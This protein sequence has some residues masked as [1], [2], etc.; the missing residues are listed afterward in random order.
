M[1]GAGELGHATVDVWRSADNFLKLL[2][3]LG[4]LLFLSLY[5]IAKANRLENFWQFSCLSL[6][7]HFRHVRLQMCTSLSRGF[8]A[9]IGMV[10]HARPS[11]LSSCHFDGCREMKELP[12]QL[13]SMEVSPSVQRTYILLVISFMEFISPVEN[14]GPWIPVIWPSCNTNGLSEQVVVASL[15]LWICFYIE[16][17]M[18]S[19]CCRI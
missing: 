17:T 14:C 12:S 7:S 19:N 5:C 9:R 4:L 15:K 2:L 16:A 10:E 18:E 3:R 11:P 6:P 8:Q 13:E 1:G